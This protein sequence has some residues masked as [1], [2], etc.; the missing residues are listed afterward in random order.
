M[1]PDYL[2]VTCTKCGAKNRIPEVRANDHPACGKCKAKLSIPGGHDG[3]V[4]VS[5]A[6]FA[7]QVVSYDGLVMLD[8]W[9]PWCGPCRT[10]GPV[11]DQMARDYRGRIR[12]AKL[13]VDENPRTASTYGIQ[14]IPTVLFFRAGN[15][16]DR[17]VGAVPRAELERHIGSLIS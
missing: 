14:S 17:V 6:D 16:V 5:D 10:L 9:A 12:V 7:R 1:V 3:P 4:A 11:V 15:V 8:C 13:N 2:Y